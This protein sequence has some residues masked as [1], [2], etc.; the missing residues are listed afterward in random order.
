MWVQREGVSL[1]LGPHHACERHWCQDL[2]ARVGGLRAIPHAL[3]WWSQNLTAGRSF[4]AWLSQEQRRKLANDDE[5]NNRVMLLQDYTMPEASQGLRLTR[6]GRHLLVTGVYPP[7]VKCYQ[8]DELSA[9]WERHLDHETL[10]FEVLTDDY[11]KVAYLGVDRWLSF[12]AKYGN[13]HKARIPILV[14]AVWGC[15]PW[16]WLSHVP[17]GPGYGV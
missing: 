8:L 17:P 6:D 2:R 11:S 15:V 4:P 7:Q 1:T 10:A 14:R 3:T 9:K 12:H 5:Y 13:Y 16:L